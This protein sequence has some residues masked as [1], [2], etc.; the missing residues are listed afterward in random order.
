MMFFCWPLILY[1][2]F[3]YGYIVLAAIGCVLAVKA[4][5]EKTFRHLA[6]LLSCILL[7]FLAHTA[8]VKDYEQRIGI[9]LGQGMP[10][11]LWVAMGTQEGGERKR[12]WKLRQKNTE[13]L[14]PICWTFMG[15]R[16]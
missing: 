12:F 6:A 16:L 1:V 11:I 9:D 5:S 15:A 8:L 10:T 3:I 13:K 2:A 7:F 14:L 4:V